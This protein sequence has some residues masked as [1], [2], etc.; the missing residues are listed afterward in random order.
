M[1]AVNERRDL[2]EAERS[3]H[4]FT[5]QRKRSTLY[6]DVTIDVQPSIHRH[7]RFGYPVS[8]PDGR[9]SFWEDSTKLRSSDWYAFRDPG[10]VWE[11][12][13]FQ[14]GS[15]HEKQIATSLEL[16]RENDLYSAM[17]GE[18]IDFLATQLVPISLA[19]YGLVAP[20]SAAVR[21]ALGDA[22]ANCLGFN[23]GFK[24]RQAQALALYS[25]E[26]EQ[27]I[28]GFSTK[29]TKRRFIEEPSWQPIRRYLERLTSLTDWAETIVAA[30]VCFE[31]LV[32]SL[33]RRE[34][35]MRVASSHGDAVTPTYGQVAQAEWGWARAWSADFVSFA[36]HDP[37]HGSANS[38]VIHGWLDDW[39]AMARE[40]LD[41]LYPVIA[42]IDPAHAE[43]RE[44]VEQDF[45]TLLH[46]CGV[47]QREV[48]A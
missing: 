33:L 35:L 46:T 36:V 24:L 14:R 9:P 18:W 17:S 37:A 48:M 38:D 40:A 10:A 7:T 19:E 15:N 27:A 23:G 8:F 29:D 1:S 47:A 2:R 41:A 34:L 16:G 20:L 13:F 22:V 21:P 45:K 39:G 28:P 43:A 26:L 11:R 5:P 25:G 31:P 4:W 32:G 12:V 6:E 42:A 44:R 30:N 3:P